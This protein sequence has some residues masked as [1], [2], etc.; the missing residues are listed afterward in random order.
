MTAL[1]DHTFSI[2][3]PEPQQ[4]AFAPVFNSAVP[5]ID[6]HLDEGR[7]GKDAIR[8]AQGS[9]SYAQLAE[10]VNRA[11]NVLATLG[12]THG[13]RVVMVMKDCPEFFYVFWGAIKA[14]FVPVPVNTLFRADDFRFLISDSGCAAIVYSSEYGAEVTPALDAARGRTLNAMTTDA[15]LERM[16]A[17]AP[18]LAP[19]PAAADDDCFFMYSSGSTGRPKGAMHRHRD[20]IYATVYHGWNNLKM[21]ERDV[22]FSAAKLFFAYAL[23]Y[24]N[25]ATLLSGATAVLVPDRPTPDMTFDAIER[26]KPTLFFGVPT[27]YAAQLRALETRKADLSSLRLCFSAGEALPGELF[28]RWKER[29]G[30]TILDGIGS[31]E[32]MAIFISNRVEDVKPGS[33]GKAVPGYQLEIRGEDGKPV[34][35]GEPGTLWVRGKT[36]AKY[37]WNNPE[38]T[39]EIIRGD[40]INTG[41]TYTAD[42][43][44]YYTYGGRSDDMMKVGGIW[45]S[46]FEIEAKLMEHSKVLEAAVVARDDGDKLIKPAA[47]I[48]LKDSKNAGEPLQ[49]ELL[50][51]CKKGLAPYKYPR[52]IEFVPDL[53]KTA[54]GKIQ[55]FKLRRQESA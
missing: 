25:T 45:C 23:I 13:D 43:D 29:T 40:W 51:H 28:R 2:A 1:P 52:W 53:P 4:I 38:K 39:A 20:V 19:A 15:F 18:T 9:V 26:F 47:Y 14:G 48:V 24:V 22:V 46:P 17:A 49:R 3:G 50:D 5:H 16:A 55:R 33:T 54:T 27:L 35:P 34:K 30:L 8:T 36:I 32:I 10:R 31:T 12:L 11:G 42:A 44:G 21:S 7:G 41:D 37:Y 6:R